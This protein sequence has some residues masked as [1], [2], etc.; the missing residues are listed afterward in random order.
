MSAPSPQDILNEAQKQLRDLERD[1]AELRQEF[2][3]D[4][5]KRILSILSPLTQQANSITS[6]QEILQ[7]ASDILSALEQNNSLRQEL[8]GNIDV[9]AEEEQGHLT[10]QTLLKGTKSLP[11]AHQETQSL[12]NSYASIINNVMELLQEKKE[13]E[14]EEEEEEGNEENR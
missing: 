5:L 4:E 2:S 6:E 8:I 1:A 14:E 12:P 13:E 10:I 7:F 9:E 11:S 3:A